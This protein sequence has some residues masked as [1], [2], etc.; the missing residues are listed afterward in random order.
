MPFIQ[1]HNVGIKLQECSRLKGAVHAVA[2][3]SSKHPAD[4]KYTFYMYISL[5]CWSTHRV[6]ANVWSVL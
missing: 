5:Q 3:T 4:R 1:L 6:F 2:T